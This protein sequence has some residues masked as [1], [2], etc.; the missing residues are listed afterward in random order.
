[1]V[2]KIVTNMMIFESLPVL[3][4]SSLFMFGS[5]SLEATT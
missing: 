3:R 2:F 1:M 4:L 5:R